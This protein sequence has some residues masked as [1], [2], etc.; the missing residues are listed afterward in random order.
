MREDNKNLLVAIVLSVAVLIGWN[1][2]YGMPTAERQRQSAVPAAGSD[3]VVAGAAP[4]EGQPSTPSPGTVPTAPG[5]A[6][7]ES[8]EAAL[9]RSPRVRID[10]PSLAG[11]IALKGGRIDDVSLKGY[12]ETVD[13][14]SPRIVLL[15]PSGGPTPYYAEF[16]WVGGSAAPGQDTLWTADSDVLTPERPLT[17]TWDNGAGLVF[18][19]VISLDP[20][21]MFTIE[22][23]VE[24][25]GSAAVSLYPYGLVSRHGKPHTQGYYVLHEGMTGVVG[26]QGLQEWGYAALDKENVIPGQSTRG[27]IWNA[28]TG[29]FL[30]ITDKYW[31]AAV[32]P[33]QAQPYQG[34]FTSRQDGTTFIYQANVLADAR[35]VQPG[36]T[37]AVTQRLFAGAK[38]TAQ[39]EAYE[40]SLGIKKF[41]LMIDWGWF[42]FITKPMFKALDFFYR[43]FGNFGVSI[44]LVTLILKGFFVPL[45]NRS[46]VSM[47]KMKAI[48][49]E[50]VALRERFK[51]DRVKQQQEMMALYKREKINPVAGCWPVVIQ[52]PVFFSL[53][54]VLFVT[55]EM[56]H[57]PFFG[58]I[59]DLAAP[60]PTSLFNLFGLLPFPVPEFLHVGVWPIIM[61][62]TM[63]LQMK[64]NPE[65]PDPVQ[66]AMFS[67]MPLIFTF[68]LASF[69]A[70][71]VIYWAWNNS[72]SVLQQAII[73]RRN[74][75]KIEL[76]DNLRGLFAKKPPAPAKG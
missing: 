31:A 2:F 29:G 72:L 56:R 53:Y 34:S 51:D 67:W 54:K 68:M 76:W 5:T 59:R 13:P 73:M 57:A 24:N 6:V 61:G 9:A 33:D 28:A 35:A 41:D 45:A 46:Y 60:D 50:M 66:K 47:A 55:I 52:I 23:T 71:L 63:F 15:S 74:G 44:L 7:V 38:E 37:V 69:P 58:W 26:D 12:H 27:K 70:G 43:M 42:Y 16:G 40:A 22:D 65:P 25:R 17:L 4:R 36:A 19:R 10:T 39:I 11:S 8:R 49:P 18:K 20:K 14:T 30:G 21:F 1:Y 62:I 32:I 64:M 75:V 3:P 48:Q